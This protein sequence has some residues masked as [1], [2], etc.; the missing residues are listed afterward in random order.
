MLGVWALL[1]WSTVAF[2]VFVWCETHEETLLLALEKARPDLEPETVKLRVRLWILLVS[3]AWLP[4]LAF[5]FV[6]LV[7]RNARR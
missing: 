3:V 4:W 6:R 7:W 5:E 2:V 1:A